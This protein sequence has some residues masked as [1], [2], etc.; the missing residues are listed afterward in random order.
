MLGYICDGGATEPDRCVVPPHTSPR[1]VRRAVER[2]TAVECQVDPADEGH[3]IVD[4]DR[5]LVVRV[6]EAHARID[7]AL[8]LVR[9]A[10]L[11][12]HHADVTARGPEERDRRALPE[13]QPHVDP[14]RELGEQ[15]TQDRRLRSP[16]Q[17]ELGREVPAEE[18]HVRCRLSKLLGD[19]REER[20]A[21][22]QHLQGIPLSCRK[23]A[24]SPVELVGCARL[25]P[26]VLPQPSGVV[27]HHRAVDRL[28]H[29]VPC[30]PSELPPHVL[31]RTRP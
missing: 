2:V 5:L 26:A 17:V 28:A 19:G 9:A 4:H 1:S 11:L 21:V 18:M 23:R 22:D 15:V 27:P 12:D 14:L 30:S 25:V 10:E 3:A 31:Q 6:H 16:G 29:R 20:G 7:L 8:N 24:M 13:Q